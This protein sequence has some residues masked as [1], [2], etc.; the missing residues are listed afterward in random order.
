MTGLSEETD[1]KLLLRSE[2]KTGLPLKSNHIQD[3]VSKTIERNDILFIF[4]NAAAP[5]FSMII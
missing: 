5:S 1:G 2:K 3:I 4:R